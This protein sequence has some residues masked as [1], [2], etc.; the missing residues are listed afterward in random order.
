M[1]ESDAGDRVF[2]AV[3]PSEAERHALARWRDTLPRAGGRPTPERDLH[4]TLAFAGDVSAVVRECLEV[5][6]TRLRGRPFALRINRAGRFKRGLF[7][8][9]PRDLPRELIELSASLSGIL[10]DCG[11]S[12]DSRPFHPHLTL[13][14]RMNGHPARV[15]PPDLLWGVEGFC[16]VRSRPSK[17]YQVLRC[18]PLDPRG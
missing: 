5:N 4:I 1:E 15:A 9:G 10:R 16:L 13:Y 2:F 3:W 8:A 14:R 12:P 18:F 11:V 17:G 7:W 6:A